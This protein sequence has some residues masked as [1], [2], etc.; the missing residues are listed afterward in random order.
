MACFIQGVRFKVTCSGAGGFKLPQSNSWK[1][2]RHNHHHTP[3]A[4]NNN[5]NIAIFP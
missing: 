2:M 3:D 5:E 1:H 4:K